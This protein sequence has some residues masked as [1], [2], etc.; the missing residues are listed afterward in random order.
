TN[1]ANYAKVTY[2]GIY[3]GID[4]VYYANSG[5]QLE[6]DFIV[7]KGADAGVIRLRFDGVDNLSIDAGGNLALSVGSET[8]TQAAPVAYQQIAGQRA[9]VE[10]SFVLLGGNEVGFRLGSYDHSQAVVIDPAY[11]YVTYLGGTG[12]D[13]ARSVAIGLD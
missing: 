1:I 4:A 7:E 12:A 2:A 8:F 9:A 5:N 13:S 11:G 6:N 3:Q 10:S